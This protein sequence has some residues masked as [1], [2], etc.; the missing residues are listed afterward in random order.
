MPHAS[1]CHAPELCT[2]QSLM[3][4]RISPSVFQLRE[5]LNRNWS[6]T[7][8][9]SDQ[10]RVTDFSW[11]PSLT[12]LF[13]NCLLVIRFFKVPDRKCIKLLYNLVFQIVFL[14]LSV[15]DPVLQ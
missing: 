1:I 13:L 14:W 15:S 2:L 11:K 12:Y 9:L 10:F 7:V 4:L 5:E 8:D 3:T 6:K